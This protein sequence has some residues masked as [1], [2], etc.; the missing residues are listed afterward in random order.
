[1]L[2]FVFLIMFLTALFFTGVDTAIAS[3]LDD[4]HEFQMIMSFLIMPLFFLSGALFPLQGLPQ[5]VNTITGL[6]P[7]TY[8]VEITCKHNQLQFGY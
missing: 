1:M 4:F 8:G 3:L 2:P 7:L 5:F 6:N